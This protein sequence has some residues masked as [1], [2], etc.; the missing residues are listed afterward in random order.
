MLKT[1]QFMPVADTFMLNYY[2]KYARAYM[3]SELKHSVM[4][5]NADYAPKYAG[6]MGLCL[7]AG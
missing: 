3:L 5:K 4:L 2:L 6:I 7:A 1:K